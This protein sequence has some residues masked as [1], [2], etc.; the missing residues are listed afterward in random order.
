MDYIINIL[1]QFMDRAVLLL[2]C[3]FTITRPH[4]LGYDIVS[5]IAAPMI[6]GQ[7]SVGFIVLLVQSIE[8]DND[9]YYCVTR[10]RITYVFNKN[11]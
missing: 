3:L 1:L 6:I 9:I 7:I 8:N 2:A 4:S 11:E 10:E 5:K